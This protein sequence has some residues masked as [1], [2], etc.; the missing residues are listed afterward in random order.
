LNLRKLIERGNMPRKRWLVLGASM[1]AAVVAV[2]LAA[3]AGDEKRMVLT[4][5]L[6]VTAFNPAT[7]AGT[8]TGTFMAAG[9]INDAGTVAATFSL[10]P[11][12]G[13]CGRL[14]GVHVLTATTG[15]LSV[16][17]NAVACPF[18]PKAPPRTYVRGKWSVV[19]GTGAYAGLD[20][21][22]RILATGDLGTGEITIARDGKIKH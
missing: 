20:G 6:Q 5:R 14:T 11:E 4:E 17:T 7:G 3:N 13:G 1:L 18:P 21:K 19:G 10:V 9:A 22:G 15:T 16:R 12:K 8:L 2:P